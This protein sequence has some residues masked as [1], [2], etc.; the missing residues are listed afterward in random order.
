MAARSCWFCIISCDHFSRI[1]ARSLPVLAL[2]AGSAACALAM[3]CSVSL[4]PSLGTDTMVLPVEGLSTGID[5]PLPAPTHL[6][7]M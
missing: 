1:A 5:A 3:A 2:Q 4:R 7:S 6:P